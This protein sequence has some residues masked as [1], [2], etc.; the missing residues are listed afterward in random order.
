[1]WSVLVR[2]VACQT[3]ISIGIISHVL[4]QHSLSILLKA[5]AR[6][7]T[8]RNGTVLCVHTSISALMVSRRRLFMC[9]P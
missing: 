4:L 5:H 9:I 6:N 8:C 7:V 1:M 2:E 3:L